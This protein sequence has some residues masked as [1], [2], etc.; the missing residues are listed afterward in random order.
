M[1][2]LLGLIGDVAPALIN[3][4]TIN[5]QSLA[6]EPGRSLVD[7]EKNSSSGSQLCPL[8][9]FKRDFPGSHTTSIQ[10]V[11]FIL[12]VMPCQIFDESKGRFEGMAYVKWILKVMDLGISTYRALGGELL[13]DEYLL[14]V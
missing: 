14:K 8:L 11:H 9:G 3:K 1:S 12:S 13:M 10:S 5:K 7:I 6:L 2:N 4:F